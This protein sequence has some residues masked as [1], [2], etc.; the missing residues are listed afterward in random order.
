MWL[1]M[2]SFLG[3][4]QIAVSD[5]GFEIKKNEKGEHAENFQVTSSFCC[6]L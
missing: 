5:G 4:I 2:L 3:G 1:L 6:R